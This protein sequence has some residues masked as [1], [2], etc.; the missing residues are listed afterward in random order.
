M[1]PASGPAARRGRAEQVSY[2]TGSY[3]TADGVPGSQ[4][5]EIRRMAFKF[6]LPEVLLSDGTYAAEPLDR[7]L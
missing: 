4:G 1:S 5:V 2:T 7:C 6:E 3:V